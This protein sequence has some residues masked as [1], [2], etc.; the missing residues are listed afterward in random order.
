[1]NYLELLISSPV[2]SNI[3][4]LLSLQYDWRLPPHQLEIRDGYFTSLKNR[5]QAMKTL[6]ASPVVLVGHSM[7]NRVIQY[8]L[9]WVVHTDRNGRRWLDD[10][11]AYPYLSYFAYQD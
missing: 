2:E 7:G 6:N 11:G 10:N 5:I 4:F 1:M 3:S 9:N 8:F